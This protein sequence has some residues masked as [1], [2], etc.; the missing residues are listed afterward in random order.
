M[1]ISETHIFLSADVN[2]SLQMR[3]REAISTEIWS[4]RFVAGERLPSTRSLAKHLGIARITVAIAYDDLAAD[5]YL[6]ANPRSGYFVSSEAPT[7]L[8]RSDPVM[9]GD[10]PHIDW[11]SRLL[12]HF[13]GVGPQA[14]PNDWRSYKYP[15]I[16]GQA[17]QSLF[18]HDA[19]RACARRALG[20]KDF[21]VIAGDFG[22][23]DDQM[24]VEQIVKRSLPDRHI[25]AKP[26]E[27]LMTL[28]AQNSLWVV[29]QML[30]AGRSVRRAVVEE[31]GYPELREILQF[32]GVEIIPIP[33]DK[34]GLCIEQIPA[35]VQAVF[36][37]PSH[38]APTGA[39]M[40]TERRVAL[41]AMAQAKDFIIVEDDYD[42][43]I[44]FSGPPRAALKSY[45]ISGRVIYLGSFSKSLF[46][47]LRLGYIV[48]PTF[49]VQEARGLRTLIARHPPGITQRITAYFLSLGH[50]NAHARLLRKTFDQRRKVLMKALAA[51]GVS[52]PEVEQSGASVWIAGPQDVDTGKVA[53]SLRSQSVL[54]EPGAPFF[55]SQ[56]P[57]KNYIRLSYSTIDSARIPDGIALV[58]QALYDEKNMA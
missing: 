10:E 35:D 42:F 7:S 29:T 33:V 41:I 12:K 27:V 4:G 52:L 5:G 22:V 47:G 3:L 49:F 56:T 32:A 8:K 48:A 37:T 26:E 17:D 40:S 44:C 38:Q 30:F 57:P 1:R 11:Q 2:A 21:N 46:P 39:T 45:D 19:W 18:P 58:M 50:Y 53:M 28:G 16:F 36:V 6:T 51:H 34:D 20:R 15:F 31:P 14:K 25:A 43:E 54:I 9:V 23:D 24:L 13:K 55:A